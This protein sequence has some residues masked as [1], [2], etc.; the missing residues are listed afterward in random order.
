MATFGNIFWAKISAVLWC[1]R[2]CRFRKNF[3]GGFNPKPCLV[4][5]LGCIQTA[6]VKR[7]HRGFLVIFGFWDFGVFGYH[8]IES[9][10]HAYLH[11]PNTQKYLLKS[12]CSQTVGTFINIATYHMP[13]CV[14]RKNLSHFHAHQ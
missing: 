9:L 8:V 14:C 7:S 4:T 3:G 13:M 5:A 1:Y 6:R 11:D 10:Y 12:F 2:L